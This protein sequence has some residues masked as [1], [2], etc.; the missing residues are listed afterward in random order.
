MFMNEWDI[1]EAVRQ[2]DDHPILGP[3]TETL[4]NLMRWTNRHSDGWAY[5]PKPCRAARKLQEL[6]Q[7]DGSWEARYGE[8]TDV[9]EAQLK[10]AYSPIKAFLTRQNATDTII[11]Q[12]TL[13]QRDE[14][15]AL[16]ARIARSA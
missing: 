1:E 4:Y 13:L 7:G 8:R 9:T 6:I 5:W 10:A 14:L 12:P 2:H 11:V 16:K 15:V 3:A